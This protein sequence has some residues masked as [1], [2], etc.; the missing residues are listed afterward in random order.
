MSAFK[1]KA[2]KPELFLVFRE[3]NSCMTNP[4]VLIR[5]Q[6]VWFQGG[7]RDWLFWI[8]CETL[9]QPLN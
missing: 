5:A 2:P 3:E 7:S 8:P 1:T 6:H 4:S 9:I